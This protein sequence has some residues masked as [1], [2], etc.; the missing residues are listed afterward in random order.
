MFQARVTSVNKKNDFF[1]WLKKETQIAPP[2]SLDQ[3]IIILAKKGIHLENN[4]TFFPRKIFLY[5]SIL[6]SFSLLFLILSKST[7][8]KLN[9]SLM[10]NP[11]MYLHYEDI[12][13][14]VEASELNANDWELISKKDKL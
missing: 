6:C 9:S 14:M 10:E 8:P 4:Q 3:K 5:T 7:I 1:Q 12:E 11:E 13:L 2:A